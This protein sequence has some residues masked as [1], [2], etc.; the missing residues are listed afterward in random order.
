MLKEILISI[1]FYKNIEFKLLV[2]NEI[3][4]TFYENGTKEL[5]RLIKNVKIKVPFHLSPRIFLGDNFP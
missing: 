3:F 1:L 5:I 2:G 4:A